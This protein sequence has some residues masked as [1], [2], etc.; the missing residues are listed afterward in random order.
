MNNNV[1]N[2][3]NNVVDSV[4]LPPR[5]NDLQL[6]CTTHNDFFEDSAIQ[7]KLYDRSGKGN[8]LVMST[9]DKMPSFGVT[10]GQF[11]GKKVM[12]LTHDGG[13]FSN[14]PTYV[15]N[16]DIDLVDVFGNASS[17]VTDPEWT[18]AMVLNETSD[19][20]DTE[21]YLSL[22]GS[23]GQNDRILLMRHNQGA[24]FRING[25]AN[26]F[27][28]SQIDFTQG[29]AVTSFNVCTDAGSDMTFEQW[30]GGV[31][32]D[33]DDTGV[34]TQYTVDPNTMFDALSETV[35]LTIGTD[36]AEGSLW[37]GEVAEILMW[38]G[39]HSAAERTQTL[40]YLQDKWDCS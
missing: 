13:R 40:N 36:T 9:A 4:V 27:D 16:T 19:S 2:N 29:T 38:K 15:N 8:H 21:Y 10:A 7:K 3:N 17:T 14:Q 39:A 34:G 33:W 26:Y 35:T 6:W 23:G 5:M 1:L 20:A 30:I 24:A 18:I 32:C 11:A 22:E 12:K 37:Y 31:A 28:T 25:N